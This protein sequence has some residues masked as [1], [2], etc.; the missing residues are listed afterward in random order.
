MGMA[1]KILFALIPLILS[2]GI[3][4]VLPFSDAAMDKD[5]ECREGL[6]LVKRFAVL[7]K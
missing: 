6:I 3:V 7:E 1:E 2:I 4:S 5:T